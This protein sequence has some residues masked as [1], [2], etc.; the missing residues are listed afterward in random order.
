LKTGV[1]LDV[2]QTCVSDGEGRRL[3]LESV[4][5]TKALGVRNSCTVLINGKK[6]CVRDDNQW[7]EC[8]VR[9]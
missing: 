7:K 9:E 3:H 8:E 5:A 6:A 4:L 1:A 2:I